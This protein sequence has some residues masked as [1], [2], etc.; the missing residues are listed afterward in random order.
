MLSSS[1][2]TSPLTATPVSSIEAVACTTVCLPAIP[3][4]PQGRERPV[5]PRA[6]EH[7]FSAPCVPFRIALLKLRTCM[8]ASER[9]SRA[10]LS[11]SRHLPDC[12]GAWHSVLKWSLRGEDSWRMQVTGHSGCGRR[13]DAGRE[14]GKARSE[15]ARPGMPVVTVIP[16]HYSSH[17]C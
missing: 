13:G 9:E 15:H 2:V 4:V 14:R 3:G 11:L 5:C 7:P 16:V 10:P 12:F 8:P 17:P 1:A 6:C